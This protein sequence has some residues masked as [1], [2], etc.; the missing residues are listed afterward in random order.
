M[1]KSW[2]SLLLAALLFGS[3]A[4]A[5]ASA[6]EPSAEQKFQVLKEKGIFA[7]FSDGSSGLYQ[8]MT[9]EQFAQVLY[10]LLELPPP[11]GSPTYKDVLKTRWSYEQIEAVREAGLMVGVG[12]S[13]FAPE[14]PVTVEQLAAVLAR[15]YGKQEGTLYVAGQVSSWARQSVGIALLND[16]I[17]QMKDYRVTATRGLLVEATYAVYMQTDEEPLDVYSVVPIGNQQIRVDLR[18]SVTAADESRFR[19]RDYRGVELTV[20][21]AVAGWDGKSI[22]VITE[23][24]I[25]NLAYT[26]YVDGVPWSFVS[27]SY[28]TERPKVV[29]FNKQWN[30]TL[31]LVFS[32][33]VD[34]DSATRRSHYSINNRL[35]IKDV[36]LSGDDRTVTI[37]TG[38]QE[39]GVSYRLTVKNVE[40]LAGNKMS[41][42]STVFPDGDQ[43]GPKASF[44]FNPS[45]ARITVTF[46]EKVNPDIATN[47]HRYSIDHGLAVT[48]AV[49]DNDGKTVYLTTSRQ[50]DA[51]VYTLTVS[52]IP[53]LAGNYMANATFQFGGVAAPAPTIQWND[54]RADNQNTLELTFSRALGTNDLS[55]LKLTILK[56]NGKD[57]SMSEWRQTARLKPGSGD[58]TA[59]VQFRTERDPNPGL[60]VQGHVYLARVSGIEGLDTA[61][62]A[63]IR[64][65]AGTEHRNAPPE[66][67]EVIPLDN[68]SIKIVFSEPVKNVSRSA[69]AIRDKDGDSL[70]IQDDGVNKSEI[71]TEVVLKLEDKTRRGHWYVI[72]FRPGTVTDAAGWNEWITKIGNE[73]AVK[74]FRGV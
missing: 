42:W 44:H 39:E 64:T 5:A 26:L 41:E 54:V 31:M 14:S 7:G 17:P 53:D 40:D 63:D 34:R 25:S 57:V 19:V 48:K 71:V 30:Q 49:L 32:E 4:A 9:R 73:D 33:P 70:E 46:N 3:V 59:I 15:L 52:G 58:K 35:D 66:V 2:I 50:K 37:T 43:S 56:D 27:L 62:D 51:T 69:F 1:L 67:K 16:W 20:F 36:S 22:T 60:F 47:L 21:D 29:S 72:S 6:A 23:P 28:D 10:K 74:A 24:Q 38:Y 55:K 61:S 12:A 68:R 18:N 13:Y 11:S 65:F 45:T 8:S